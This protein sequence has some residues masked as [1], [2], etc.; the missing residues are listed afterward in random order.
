[1]EKIKGQDGIIRGGRKTLIDNNI[2]EYMKSN[3]T[4][5]N[6]E[7]RI[8]LNPQQFQEWWN[9]EFKI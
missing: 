4:I 3:K 1:M 5:L 6:I 8:P 9:S 2:V 7:E